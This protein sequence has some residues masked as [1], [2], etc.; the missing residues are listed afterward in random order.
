MSN[1]AIKKWKISIL[2]QA[3]QRWVPS[4]ERWVE[5]QQTADTA[6]NVF[7]GIVNARQ[8][9]LPTHSTA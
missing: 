3:I 6:G 9:L 4:F 2:S 1:V 5:A 7:N 8:I